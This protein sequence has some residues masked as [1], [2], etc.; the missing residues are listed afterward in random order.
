MG[1]ESKDGH[2]EGTGRPETGDDEMHPVEKKA[3]ELADGAAESVRRSY[4]GTKEAYSI[5]P[6]QVEPDEEGAQDQRD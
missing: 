5:D 3:A 2:T 1:S 6:G 4:D